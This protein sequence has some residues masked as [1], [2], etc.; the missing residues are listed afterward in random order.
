M[1]EPPHSAPGERGKGYHPR[2][3]TALVRTVIDDYSR[4]AYA[5]IH[6][7]EKANTAERGVIVERVLSDNG[8]AYKSHAWRQACA[9]PGITPKRTRPYRPQTNGTIE[10]FHRTGADGWAYALFYESKPS[11]GRSR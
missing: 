11:L 4:T 2:I 8:P 9:D 3:G 1:L 5:E 6:I 10:R 7:D